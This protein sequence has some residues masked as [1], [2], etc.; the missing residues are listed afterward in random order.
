MVVVFT[1]IYKM[2][3]VLLLDYTYSQKFFKT[4]FNASF[5]NCKQSCCDLVY[6]F[7]QAMYIVAVS[8]ESEN[9]IVWILCD[10]KYQTF[11]SKQIISNNN[12][13][14]RGMTE[15]RVGVLIDSSYK[16]EVFK[17]STEWGQQM[18]VS[19]LIMQIRFTFYHPL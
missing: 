11:C 19:M 1:F 5:V 13:I 16:T 2:S 18:I 3:W 9:K 8:W 10:P 15:S 14:D 7:G 12:Y 6:G 4:V 17:N